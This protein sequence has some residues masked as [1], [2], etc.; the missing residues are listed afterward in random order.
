MANALL[1]EALRLAALGLKVFPLRPRDKRPITE[2]GVYDATTDEETIRGWWKETPTANLAL[3][4]DGLL[5]VDVDAYKLKEGVGWPGDDRKA[6]DLSTCPTQRSARGGLHYV[7]RPP[8]GS[9]YGNTTGKLAKGVDTRGSGGYIVIAP[10]QIG[11]QRY[12]WVQAIEDLDEIPETFPWLLEELDKIKETGGYGAG[13]FLGDRPIPDGEQNDTLFR[14]GA[15][16]RRHGFSER[17]I[18]ATLLAV[19][20]ERCVDAEGKPWPHPEKRVEKI[21]RSCMR[22]EPDLFATAAMEDAPETAEDDTYADPGRFPPHLLDKVPPFIG[23]VMDYTLATAP[24]PQPVFALAGALSL[25]SALTGRKIADESNLRSNILSLIVG[26]SGSGKD[27]PRQVNREI[28]DAIGADD[29]LGSEEI[30]SG[31]GVYTIA[32]TQPA[33]L[34]QLDEIG[35]MLVRIKQSRSDALS[36]VITT[37]MKLYSA[38]GG[39]CKIGGYADPK[40]NF[41]LNQPH[42]VV[43]G[44]TVMESFAESLSTEALHDGF[45][46]RVLLFN[47]AEFPLDTRVRSRPVPPEIL[48]MAEDWWKFQPVAGNL[49]AANPLPRI[50]RYTPGALEAIQEFREFT[51]RMA[52]EHTLWTRAIEKALKVALNHSAAQFG[53]A[54]ET[55]DE[56]AFRWSAQLVEYQTRETLWIASQWVSDSFLETQTKRVIRWMRSKKRAVTLSEYT[57]ANQSIPKKTREEIVETLRVSGQLVVD[58]QGKTTRLLLK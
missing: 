33:C 15:W 4:C 55:V 28:L 1:E 29:L 2:H 25:V 16:L 36:N 23:R 14:I 27:R 41:M 26:R 50:V 40:R 35:K 13:G 58:K 39:P 57:R 9:D 54:I 45:L 51:W 46:S 5:V 43:L 31:N 8:A 19:S 52:N 22:Y 7:T 44:T 3:S 42:C 6:D 56:A 49:V 11:G 21:A 32:R 12:T 34:L 17:Q 47:S 24:R 48:G 10:S 20:A 18:G 37:I 38:S 53:P 30:Q